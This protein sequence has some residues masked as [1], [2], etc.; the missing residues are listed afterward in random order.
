MEGEYIATHDEGWRIVVE[1]N[2]GVLKCEDRYYKFTLVPIGD[3]KFV[4]PR[5]GALWRFDTTDP[6]AKPIMLFGERKFNKV[7]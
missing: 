2:S 4:N 3:D 1:V 7:K 5:F 6:D